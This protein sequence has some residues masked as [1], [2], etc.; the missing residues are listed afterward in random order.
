MS[1]K[2][3][4]GRHQVSC[5]FDGKRKYFY[6]KTLSEARKKRD[7]Y[8]ERV[9][10]SPNYDESITLGQWL[11]VWLRGMKGSLRPS[12]FQSYREYMQ[13]YILTTIGKYKLVELQPSIF[14]IQI[15]KMLDSGLSNR[16]V[17][18]A[19]SIVRHALKQAVSD[20]LLAVSPMRGV[21]LPKRIKTAVTSLSK[22]E[23]S[24]L[25]SVIPN[26]KHYNLYWTALY[27]GLRR[28]EILGLRI[29]DVDFKK[30][31]ITIRQTVVNVDNTVQIS[32]TT[33]NESSRRTI[34]IDTKTL[35]VLKNQKAL[36]YAD[37]MKMLEY[38]DNDL[39]FARPDGNPLDP[40]YISHTANNYGRKAE[41]PHLSFH[42]LR[43]T[44][45]TL[46][47]LAGV[48]FKVIQHRLGH[49]TFQQTMDTY[50][51]VLPD[52]EEQVVDKLT[53]LI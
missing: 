46:L 21:Q 28:G 53:A 4:D 30:G 44:H 13:R 50:S 16:T 37:R 48:H 10:Q 47:L 19:F 1:K 20:G 35:S 11:A 7:V 25:L 32:S 14:R 43:H 52:I 27:T 36:A 41:L 6:G 26:K 34:S 42:M 3:A 18:Y 9:T 24:K 40:K 33:K 22:E 38:H 49:S 5:V 15:A 2:R 29:S 17:Q 12:T 39:L 8:V 45:A 23:A 31:T 51:H